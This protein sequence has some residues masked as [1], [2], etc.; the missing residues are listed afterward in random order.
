MADVELSGVAKHFGA[1]RVLD[2]VNLRV[3]DGEFIVFVGPSGCGKSTLLRL[4]AGLEDITRGELRIGGRR[5]L[6]EPKQRADER[7]EPLHHILPW[8]V[9]SP[10]PTAPSLQHPASSRKR[11]MRSA[12]SSGVCCDMKCAVSSASKVA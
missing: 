11:V 1:T 5:H 9:R 8:Y 7:H 4:I 10:D 3:E 12:T 2:D 6:R